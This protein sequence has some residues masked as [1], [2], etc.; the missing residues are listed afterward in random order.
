[1]NEAAFAFLTGPDG[2]AA[3]ARLAGADLSE[4]CTLALLDDL[5]RE[6]PPE[7]AGAALTLARLRERGAAK[8]SRAG[9]MLFTPEALEQASGEAVA[10][11]RARRFAEAGYARIADLGCGGFRPREI[12]VGDGDPHAVAG[13]RPRDGTAD[14]GGGTGYDCALAHQISRQP[15]ALC[16]AGRHVG[17]P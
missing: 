10:R 3:L 13:E 4:A 14:S 8:F 15:V 7:L 6:L 9:A 17:P 11:W 2:R 5:R 12:D 1:M 16:G